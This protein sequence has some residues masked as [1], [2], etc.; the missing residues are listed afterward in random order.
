MHQVDKLCDTIVN[1][2]FNGVTLAVPRIPVS[3]YPSKC[4]RSDDFKTVTN[5]VVKSVSSADQGFSL[6][7]ISLS[8]AQG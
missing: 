5:S 7:I 6:H 8:S 1:L 2:N 4:L 3:I